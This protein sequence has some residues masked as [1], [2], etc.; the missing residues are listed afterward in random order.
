MILSAR[1]KEFK[2]GS[3]LDAGRRVPKATV[4]PIDDWSADRQ[5]DS[6]P[7]RPRRKERIEDAVVIFG[8]DT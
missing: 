3:V 6:H 1:H 2:H 4:V 5:S 7:V 8:I